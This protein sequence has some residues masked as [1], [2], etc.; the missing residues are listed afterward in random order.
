M[1]GAIR[2]WVT[3]SFIL[4]S[5]VTVVLLSKSENMVPT[6]G[7]GEKLDLGVEPQVN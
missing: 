2:V 3:C 1:C 5:A 4:K 6:S 7:V